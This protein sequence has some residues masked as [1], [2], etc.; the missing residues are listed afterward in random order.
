MS[1]KAKYQLH[2]TTLQLSA[3]SCLWHSGG[4]YYSWSEWAHYN[5]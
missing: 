3:Y 1:F 4:L 5:I 2:N